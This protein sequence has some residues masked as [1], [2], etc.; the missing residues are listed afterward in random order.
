MSLRTAT[1]Y[2]ATPVEEGERKVFVPTDQ[3]EG[4]ASEEEKDVD[5]DEEEQAKEKRY[6]RSDVERQKGLLVDFPLD[7]TQ[8]SKN[9]SRCQQCDVKFHLFNWKHHCRM[10][11]KTI[12]QRCSQEFRGERVCY[13]CKHLVSAVDNPDRKSAYQ[14]FAQGGA[15][16]QHLQEQESQ[17]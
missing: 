12:C 6:R 8:W 16:R 4:E 17:I 2:I 14:P 3:V 15:S 11:G 7:K 1:K 5:A 13:V 10:C 9:A